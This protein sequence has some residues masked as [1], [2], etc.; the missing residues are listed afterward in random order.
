MEIAKTKYGFL[1][2]I[3]GTIYG[4][5]FCF[6]ASGTNAKNVHEQLIREVGFLRAYARLAA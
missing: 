3:K 1:G 5:H 2:K 4:I 6:Y